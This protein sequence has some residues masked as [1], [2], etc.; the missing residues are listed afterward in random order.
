MLRRCWGSRRS[1]TC[2]ETC[3]G[4]E[5][6]GLDAALG[7]AAGPVVA[8]RQ[9]ELGEEA[10]T[11]H[12]LAFSGFGHIRELGPDGGQAEHAACLDDAGGGGLLGESSLAGKG[13]G[14]LLYDWVG[15]SGGRSRRSRS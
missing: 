8:L 1:R 13:H 11:G 12:L 10:E 14:D 7:A 9:E 4:G 3:R 15:R 2:A 5:P 6:G